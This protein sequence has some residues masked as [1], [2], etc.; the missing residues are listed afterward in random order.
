MP[1]VWRTPA[2]R[3]DR[4]WDP[5]NFY[6]VDTKQGCTDFP[7]I[8]QTLQNSSRQK[9]RIQQGPS[10]GPTDIRCHNGDPDVKLAVTRYS[11]EVKNKWSFTPR[12]HTL[13]YGSEALLLI[14][15]STCSSSVASHWDMLDV[16][17][18]RCQGLRP[19]RETQT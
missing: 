18:G 2:N 3:L 13:S 5:P 8:S 7:K 16:E 1:T 11:A 14:L 9:R 17:G 10:W 12:P 4:P 19:H 6:S 15:V